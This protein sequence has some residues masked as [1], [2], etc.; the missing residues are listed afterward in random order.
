[1]SV[2][3]D[4]VKEIHD[5]CRVDAAGNGSYDKAVAASKHYFETYHGI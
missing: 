3:I 1:M 2:T 4:G 5:L